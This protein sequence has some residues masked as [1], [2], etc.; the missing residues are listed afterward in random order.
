[1]LDAD[2]AVELDSLRDQ[3]RVELVHALVEQCREV[4]RQLIGLLETGSESVGQSRDVR[5]MH[6]LCE[7]R[8]LLDSALKLRVVV[9]QEPL[10]DGLLDLLVVFF[11]EE[12]V[13]EE[14]H[15]THYE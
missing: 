7:L 10:E 6:V 13:L 11:L 14:G 1:V 12:F 8:L 2:L 4:S 5:H 15:R 3:V 9:L